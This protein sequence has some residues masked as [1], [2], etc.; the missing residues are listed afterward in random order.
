MPTEIVAA[1]EVLA[2]PLVTVVG[3]L[4]VVE[5]EEVE[6]D[7]VEDPPQPAMRMAGRRMHSAS[8]PR[9]HLIIAAA[10]TTQI[11]LQAPRFS[12]LQTAF[13]AKCNRSRVLAL[14]RILISLGSFAGGEIDG[15]LAELVWI[16]GPLG[17]AKIEGIGA[18]QTTVE[19]RHP[20]GG[21][22]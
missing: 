20:F 6:V 18:L 11:L 13:A 10:R 19:E 21:A 22:P 2:P 5:A 1:G 8:G 14:A 7:E 15:Q 16:S 3:V 9:A 17:R 4:D 12:A